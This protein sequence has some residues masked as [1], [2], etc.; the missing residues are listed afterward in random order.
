MFRSRV[1]SSYPT[2]GINL[3]VKGNTSCIKTEKNPQFK[4][5]AFRFIDELKNQIPGLRTSRSTIWKYVK[6]IEKYT[7]EA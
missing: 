4:K 1:S 5:N 7:G 3:Y 2:L 6:L